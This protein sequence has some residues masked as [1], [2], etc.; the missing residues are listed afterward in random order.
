MHPH[1][2]DLVCLQFPA[3]CNARRP[4]HVATLPAAASCVGVCDGVC[5][6]VYTCADTDAGYTVSERGCSLV[7]ASDGVCG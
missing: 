2:R 5:D 7:A 3:P 1:V 4:M 6:A